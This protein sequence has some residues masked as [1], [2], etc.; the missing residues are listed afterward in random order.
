MSKDS[1]T[2]QA[3]AALVDRINL[4]INASLPDFLKL[5]SRSSP[6]QLANK[7]VT[8]EDKRMARE[9]VTQFVRGVTDAASA[10]KLV[11]L[12]DDVSEMRLSTATGFLGRVEF[13]NVL[14]FSLLARGKT[15]AVVAPAAAVLAAKPA[16]TKTA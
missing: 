15:P 2:S 12:V 3:S 14:L 13:K 6:L 7:I 10:D 9:S 8:A 4:E 1:K 11:E 5:I 16:P